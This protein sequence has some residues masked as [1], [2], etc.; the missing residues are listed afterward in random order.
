MN[1]R[2]ITPKMHG[3]IDYG[4]AA[5]QLVAPEV[6]GFNKKAKTLYRLFSAHLFTYSALTD[7]P[8]GIKPVLSYKAHHKIDIGNVAVLAAVTLYDGIKKDKRALPFHIGM[9]A[10]A[11]VNVLLTDWKADPHAEEA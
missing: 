8:M 4:F 10:L 7:Y 2:P 9:V 5:A 11:M 6:L 1:K 3:L